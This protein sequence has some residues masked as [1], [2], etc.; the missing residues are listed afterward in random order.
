MKLL[1]D[2]RNVLKLFEL[3]TILLKSFTS[4]L[5][6]QTQMML[7]CYI[8]PVIEIIAYYISFFYRNHLPRPLRY[9]SKMRRRTLFSS[10]VSIVRYST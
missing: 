4:S 3:I 7:L 1:L 5:Y 6:M 8:R 9:L 2:L 10:S